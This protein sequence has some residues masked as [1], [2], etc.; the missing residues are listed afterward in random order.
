MFDLAACRRRQ[1]RLLREMAAARLDAAIVTQREHVQWLT[2][3][4][5]SHLFQPVATLTAEGHCLLVAPALKRPAES[6]ADEIVPYEA[7]WLFTLRNDQRQESSARLLAALKSR[8]LQGGERLRRIGVEYSSYCPHLAAGLVA[9]TVDVEPTL[10]YLRRRKE[11]DELA[12]IKKA[13]AACGKMYERAR[14][15]VAPGVNELT[16]FNELQSAAVE[17][18]AEPLTATGN[19]YASG[20]RGGPP[21]D[22]ATR[23]GELYVLDLGPA[24]RGYFSDTARTLAV[25]GR[26]TDEQQAA[27]EAV[28]E[29]FTFTE[30]TVKPG[31]NCRE[32]FHEVH[33]R[34]NAAGRGTFDHHLGHGIGLFPHEAPHLNP[35]W[36]DV[37]EVGDVF[38]IEPGL[39]AP[40]LNVGIRLENDYLVTAGGVELLSPFPLQ[41]A[42]T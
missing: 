21:R 25:N 22:R 23:D 2:G 32:F 40:E 5:F 20:V 13:I 12:M 34:L 42:A 1:H 9:E 27:S 3:C 10:L 7:Q 41:L 38:A 19:D 4:W 39:Y 16:V 26:P 33:E 28:A 15:I 35:N 24:F 18:F 17:E 30:R 36:N 11:S 29:I 14:E 37:F 8:E 6:A 31:L